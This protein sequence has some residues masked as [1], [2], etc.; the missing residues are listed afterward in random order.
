[1]T[2]LETKIDPMIG[3]IMELGTRLSVLECRVER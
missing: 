3:K 1:M 2:A